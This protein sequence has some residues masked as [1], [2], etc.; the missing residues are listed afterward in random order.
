LVGPALLVDSDQRAGPIAVGGDVWRLRADDDE[1]TGSPRTVQVEAFRG[2]QDENVGQ[3]FELVVWPVADQE[4]SV[5]VTYDI[6]PDAITAENPFPYGGEAHAET[7]LQA[8]VAAAEL[9]RDGVQGPQAAEY[10]ARLATS[11]SVDRRAKPTHY[12][13]NADRS[14]GPHRG[15]RDW[16]DSGYTVTFDGVESG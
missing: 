3:R 6:Q 10:M 5:R 12:G 15:R 16:L 8:C 14:D 9:Q 2:P 7:F 4:Y 1:R 13:Y 11:V